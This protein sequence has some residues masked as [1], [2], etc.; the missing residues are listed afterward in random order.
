MNKFTKGPWACMGGLILDQDSQVIGEA[1]PSK[2]CIANA[3]LIAAAP[4]MYEALKYQE[5]CME[6]PDGD[7]QTF[8]HMRDAA[9][10]KAEDK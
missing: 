9:L 3:H 10:A 1:K 7:L 6:S 5:L 2:E 4:D 8:L